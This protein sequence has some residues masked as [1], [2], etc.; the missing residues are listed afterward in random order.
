LPHSS[1]LET[2]GARPL[3]LIGITGTPGTGKKSIAAI[4]AADL[5][6]PALSLNDYALKRGLA[7]GRKGDRTVDTELLKA[8]LVHHLKGPCVV[9]GHLLVDVL[10]PRSVRKVFVLR[11]EPRELKKRLEAR[12]YVG[13]KLREN[14]EAELIGVLQ[15]LAV[16]RYG[17][18]RVIE[19]DTTRTRPQEAAGTVVGLLSRPRKPQARIDW[20]HSYTS[21]V[22]L[23]SLLSVETTESALI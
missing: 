2:S 23:K 16:A 9:Y 7:K 1:N 4:V 8:S 5:A 14:L 18:S 17:E 3:G 19:V 21:A 20:T 15:S 13:Q 11:C 6:I 22:K 12:G 10:G